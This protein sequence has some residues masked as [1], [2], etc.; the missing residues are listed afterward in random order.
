MILLIVFLV[1]FQFIF[2]LL[3]NVRDSHRY[4]RVPN[5]DFLNS[6]KILLDWSIY[7]FPSLIIYACAKIFNKKKFNYLKLINDRLLIS[8]IFFI[9]NF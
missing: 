3:D 7:N 1:Q 6:L 9:L 2:A 8:L 4:N 5:N